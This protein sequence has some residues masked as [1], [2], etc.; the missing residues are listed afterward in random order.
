MTSPRPFDAAL[1]RPRSIGE[2][3]DRGFTVFIKTFWRSAAI[4]ALVA[5]LSG[6]GVFGFF[7]GSA[8]IRTTI[9]IAALVALVPVLLIVATAFYALYGAEAQGEPID[10]R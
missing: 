8:A 3:F 10:T 5:I 2:I 9:Q 6:A 7:A 4:L 1:L